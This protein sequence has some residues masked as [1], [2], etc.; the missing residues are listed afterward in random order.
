MND[1]NLVIADADILIS[2][3]SA[4]DLNHQIVDDQTQKLVNLAYKIKFPMRK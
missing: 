2:L 1:T 3:Y 4:D